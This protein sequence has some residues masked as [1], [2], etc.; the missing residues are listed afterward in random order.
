MITSFDQLFK[1]VKNCK[2]GIIAVAAAED[3]KEMMSL[4]QGKR[5]CSWS[6]CSHNHKLKS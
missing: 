1:E 4:C 2:F 3:E 5:N 6:R